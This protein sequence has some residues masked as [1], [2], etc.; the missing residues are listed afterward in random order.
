[1]D[2]FSKR[3]T[4]SQETEYRGAVLLDDQWLIARQKRN[5]S[6]KPFVSQSIAVA[7]AQVLSDGVIFCSEI[8]VDVTRY[9]YVLTVSGVGEMGD[10]IEDRHHGHPHYMAPPLH[11][12]GIVSTDVVADVI[13]FS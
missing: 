13:Q 4:K 7:I 3:I 9:S 6:H 12:S 2:A 5:L 11:A 1:M 10:G 8:V